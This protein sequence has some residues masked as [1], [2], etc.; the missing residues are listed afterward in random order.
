M[1]IQPLVFVHQLTTRI[2]RN[3]LAKFISRKNLLKNDYLLQYK[4]TSNAS[5]AFIFHQLKIPVV[6][7][8]GGSIHHLLG[9]E[10]CGFICYSEKSWYESIKRLCLDQK[11]NKE[12]SERAFQLMKKLYDP[13]IWCERFIND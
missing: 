8:I 13:N 9:D 5:R 7:E 4:N 10:R 1:R 12:F 11:L 3:N 6:A 2:L